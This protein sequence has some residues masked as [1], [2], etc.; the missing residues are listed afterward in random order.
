MLLPA[1]IELTMAD[2]V[3]D[4]GDDN[5]DDNGCD[6]LCFLCGGWQPQEV[7]VD[8]SKFVSQSI[9][10][11][12]LNHSHQLKLFLKFYLV[13]FLSV[14][15]TIISTVSLA[16]SLSLLLWLSTT[17]PDLYF[18]FLFCRFFCVRISF[19]TYVFILFLFLNFFF[20]SQKHDEKF[21]LFL[22]RFECRIFRSPSFDW[23]FF[24]LFFFVLHT[25]SL[26]I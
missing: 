14:P 26:T 7:P 25:R 10:R 13:F 1:I 24:F 6:N 16:L 22:L 8:A 19:T 9:L 2:D 15:C 5:D 23:F 11:N 20:S 3:E 21:N 18:T 17:Q 12:Y 4:E